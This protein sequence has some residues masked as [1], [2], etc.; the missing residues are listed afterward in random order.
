[1][2][3]GHDLQGRLQR[4]LLFEAISQLLPKLSHS[5][6]IRCSVTEFIKS[7]YYDVVL[8]IHNANIWTLKTI[9]THSNSPSFPPPWMWM[10]TQKGPPPAFL[11]LSSSEE[12]GSPTVHALP[13][14]INLQSS[15]TSPPQ[16][17][18]CVGG[19]SSGKFHP[20][21]QVPSFFIRSFD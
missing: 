1:M 21:E 10:Q 4:R 16:W 18:R 6:L 11:I 5:C 13:L 8:V 20:V 14:L 3:T 17:N 15:T 9:T 7:L 19:T 12:G 2:I